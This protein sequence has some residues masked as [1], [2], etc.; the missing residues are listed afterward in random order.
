VTFLL[1][2]LALLR[3]LKEFGGRAR[4]AIAAAIAGIAFYVAYLLAVD[5][6]MYFGRWQADLAAGK[7][8][9]D[10]ASGLHDLRTHWV[11]TRDYTFWKDEIPWMSL[12]FS[13]AVWS[14]L[15]LC[16]FNLIICRLPEYRVSSKK[17]GTETG[18][19]FAR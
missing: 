19:E 18:M 10:L 2:A 6:P 16:G 3:Q 9:L 7:P 4:V 17:L 14:S 5:I 11:V 13:A 15:A 8:L 1:I 12:Y